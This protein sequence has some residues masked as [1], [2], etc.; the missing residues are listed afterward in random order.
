MT[1]VAAYMRSP[2]SQASPAIGTC[3]TITTNVRTGSASSPAN[4]RAG[5]A[6]RPKC[7]ECKLLG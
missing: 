2:R 6:H 3:T 5:T 4:R 1:K 7:D